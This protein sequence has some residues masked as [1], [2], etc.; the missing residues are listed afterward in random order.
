MKQNVMNTR[1]YE[2]MKIKQ[3]VIAADWGYPERLFKKDGIWSGLENRQYTDYDRVK[4]ITCKD[5]TDRI[6]W[7]YLGNIK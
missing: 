6:H 1:S 3:G 2:Y 7:I 4:R 5:D